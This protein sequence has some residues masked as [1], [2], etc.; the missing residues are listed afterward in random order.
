MRLL[1]FGEL[2]PG[3]LARSLELGLAAEATVVA[4]NPYRSQS[5][6]SELP[7]TAAARLGRR[8]NHRSRVMQAGRALVET[9]EQLRPDAALVV[10]GRGVDAGSITHVRR[11][12]V[13]V[14]VYYPDN[15]A[16]AFSDTQGVKERLV[17][18][19]LAIVWSERLAAQLAAGGANARVL[20]FGYD[21]RWWGPASPGGDRH[22]IVFLGQWSPR[23]E[24][25]LAALA[26]LP[27]T[28]RG[29]GWDHT[30]VPAGPPVFG[31]SAGALLAGAEIGV[32]VLH[33]A[34]AGAHNMRTREIPA[35]GALQLTNPGTDGTPLRDRTSCAWFESPAELRT[36]A[37]NYLSHRDEAAAIAGEGQ[38]L[39]RDDTY[40]ERGRTLAR[41]LAEL[42]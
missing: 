33:L 11:L 30:G 31:P 5:G 20:P 26:G 19:T 34:N 28:V 40:V 17:A 36:L 10:K 24:R 27:L 6:R 9:A 21:T 37:E 8:L 13:P 23:R 42:V 16:W 7:R 1:L 29:G 3:T 15:P 38:Q 41:W 35:T 4:T 18:S 39:T 25:Y 2:G 32:N 14:A 22:G 12:G